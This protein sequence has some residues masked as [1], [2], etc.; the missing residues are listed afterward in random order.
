[1]FFPP[2]KLLAIACRSHL[3]KITLNHLK[4]SPHVPCDV[5]CEPS[6]FGGYPPKPAPVRTYLPFFLT[7]SRFFFSFMFFPPQK[8]LVIACR[9]HLLKTTPI[10]L[11]F[12]PHVPFDVTCEPSQFGDHPPKP[13]PVAVLGAHWNEAFS[14]LQIADWKGFLRLRVGARGVRV[15]AVG[16]DRVPRGWVRWSVAVAKVAVAA[17]WSGCGCGCGWLA[18]EAVAVAS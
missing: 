15:W 11:K 4:F 6:E 13:A 7:L 14:S 5:T 12:S 8:L 2:Q 9:S 16:V 1:M 3:L 10:F 18:G 17:S